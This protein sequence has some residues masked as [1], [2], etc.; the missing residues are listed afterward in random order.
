MKWTQKMRTTTTTTTK[1]KGKSEWWS[2]RDDEQK[3]EMVKERERK[4]KEFDGNCRLKHIQ[5]NSME[6]PMASAN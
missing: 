3:K 2:D 4:S 5:L 6:L 1:R